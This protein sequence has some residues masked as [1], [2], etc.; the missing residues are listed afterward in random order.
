MQ[1]QKPGRQLVIAL[2][3]AS[4]LSIVCSV[5]GGC[6]ELVP[7]TQ[8]ATANRIFDRSLQGNRLKCTIDRENPS[9][10]FTFHF[11]AGFRISCPVL[12]FGGQRTRVWVLAR[13][14]P[15]GGTPVLLGMVTIF[16]HSAIEPSL[17]AR[18]GTRVFFHV[19]GGF[20]VGE[21][22][23]RVEVALS[24]SQNRI[25]RRAWRIKIPHR[26]Q[27]AVPAVLAANQVAPLSIP[28]WHGPQHKDGLRLAILLSAASHNP[29]APRLGAGYQMMLL[30]IL[31]TL[32]QQVPCKSVRLVAFNLDQERVI[33]RADSFESTGFDD[34]QRAFNGLNL[35]VVSVQTLRKRDEWANMLTTL[36]NQQLTAQPPPD[37][38]IILGRSFRYVRKLPREMMMFHYEGMP[39]FFYFENGPDNLFPDSLSFLIKSLKGKTYRVSTPHDLSAAIEKMLAHVQEAGPNGET[40]LSSR[41]R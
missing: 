10:D 5:P 37:A 39:G 15:E 18:T 32:L 14:T 3:L 16:R 33:Y 38:V 36:A 31:S 19:S 6:Q 25:C 12:Q 26:W 22:R 35:G 9:L 21:G 2:G 29:R 30:Q 23:Y 8:Q 28:P 1:G 27:N 41:D 24:D 11:D 34:L 20:S 17:L 13:V 7:P 4:L 40:N